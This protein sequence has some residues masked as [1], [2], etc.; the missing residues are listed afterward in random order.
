[1]E[2]K[3]KIEDILGKDG[4]IAKS[5]KNYDQRPEQIEMAKAVAEAILFSSHLICEAGTGIGKSI[6]YLVPFIY[7]AT[8]EKKRVVISTY[9]KTLQ[10]QLV[11]KDL[12]FLKKALGIDVQFSLCLGGENYL[13]LR[14]IRAAQSYD[15]FASKEAEEEL[16]GLH[17]WQKKTETGLKQ[18]LPFEPSH[19]LWTNVCRMRDLCLGNECL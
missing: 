13:C 4:A 7:W 19:Q 12:P 9:T 15:L 18:D 11:Q 2:V 14:R 6:A 1:M 5:L 10:Q 16:T 17:K 3:A 8:K